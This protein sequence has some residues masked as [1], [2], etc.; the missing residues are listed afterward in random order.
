M[1]KF[2]MNFQN[3]ELAC[4]SGKDRDSQQ[5]NDIPCVFDGDDEHTNNKINDSSKR[6]LR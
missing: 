2:K 6:T 4:F 5:F 1:F 3:C